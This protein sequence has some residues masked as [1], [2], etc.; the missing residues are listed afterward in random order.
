[1]C[2]KFVKLKFKVICYA[3]LYV[4]EDVDVVV[5]AAVVVAVDLTLSFAQFRPSSLKWAY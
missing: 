3:V 5:V 2:A 4:E 1:M